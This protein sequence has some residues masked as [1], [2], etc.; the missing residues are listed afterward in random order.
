M[1]SYHYYENAALGTVKQNNTVDQDSAVEPDN[2]NELDD[3]VKKYWI[4]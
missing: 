3:E 2:A 1:T 4:V